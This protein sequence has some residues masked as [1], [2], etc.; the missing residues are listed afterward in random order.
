MRDVLNRLVLTVAGLGL[1]A[2]ALPASGSETCSPA[3]VREALQRDPGFGKRLES[4]R[5]RALA[6]FRSHPEADDAVQETLQ[7]V[8]KGRP[9]LFLEAGDE[10]VRYLRAATRRNLA[11]EIRKSAGPGVRP[12]NGTDQLL[13]GCSTRAE[14]PAEI[15][16]SEQLLEA[17][18]ARL[19]PRD[20][21]ILE[22]YLDG[23]T[24]QRGIARSLG[25]TRY[26]VSSATARIGDE[27][28]ALL[29]GTC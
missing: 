18:A 10:V 29:G 22:A 7:R 15:V 12:V 16:A 3:A 6:G 5:R 1:L 8:W 25:L 24:S 26:A 19:E 4:Y 2:G 21:E 13:E 14:D 20:L 28:R 11:T 27:L 9:G 17:L 23:A